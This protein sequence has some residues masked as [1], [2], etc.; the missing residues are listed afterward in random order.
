[1]FNESF[2]AINTTILNALGVSP[3]SWMTDAMWTRMALIMIQT[4]LGFPYI[5]VIVTEV[6]QAIRDEL[7]EAETVD[8]ATIFQ[9][10]KQI[11]YPLVMF[12]IAP[13]LITQYTF[14]FYNF[15][16]FFF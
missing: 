15:N 6:L 14:N 7:Y 3:I 5:F 16:F 10:F 4:W 1:M 13:L 11:T 2:G 12:S 8:G 9:M